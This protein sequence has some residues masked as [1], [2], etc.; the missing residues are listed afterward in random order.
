MFGKVGSVDGG[1]GDLEG[2]EDADY[3]MKEYEKNAGYLDGGDGAAFNDAAT[4]ASVSFFFPFSS[5]SLF[6]FY[7]F[8]FPLCFSLCSNIPDMS[9]LSLVST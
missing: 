8:K 9:L 4:G 6:S 3:N 1:K 5:P 7:F 2:M